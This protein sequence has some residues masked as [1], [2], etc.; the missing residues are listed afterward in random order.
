MGMRKALLASAA[1]G[2]LLWGDPASAG[3][4]SGLV[5]TTTTVLKTT[6]S[7]LGLVID[8]PAP[9]DGSNVN[10]YYG[11]INPFY[12]SINP[13]YGSINPFY[14]SISP[15]WGDISPFWGDINPFYGSISPF[16]GSINPFWGTANPFD[17]SIGPFWQQAGP[18]WGA[19]NTTWTN[20]QASNASDY[21]SLQAQLKAFFAQNASFWNAAVLKYTGKNFNE[22]FAN[23]MLAEYGINPDDPSSLAKIDPVVRSAF[24]LN[25]YDGLM[26]FT[27]VDHVDWW[28]SAVNWSPAL[29]DIQDATSKPII[30]G[31]LDSTFSA[32]DTG[33]QN[34]DFVGGY[35]YY[36]NQH[37]GAVASLIAAAHDGKAIMGI[38]PNVQVNLYN[39]FDQTGTASWTDVQKGIAALYASGAHV[40]NASLGVPGTVLSQEWVNILT[41][42]LL[43]GRSQDLVIVKAAGNDG[44]VQTTNISWLSSLQVPQ[45]LLIVGSVGPTGQISSFSNTPGNACFTVL[46]LCT[47]KLMNHYLVAPGELILVS[48]GHG[49]VTRMTGTSFAAPLV[50]GAVALLDSRWPWLQQHAPE[51]VQIILQ[52]AKDLGAP[53]VDPVY[54]WGELDIQASQSPLNFDNLVVFQPFTYNGN[55]LNPLQTLLPNWS[56]RSLKQSVLTPGQLDIWQN[57]KAYLVAIEP[58]GS[59][60][61]DFTI[62]L[63]TMLVGKNQKTAYG[64]NPFQ[65]YLYQR[66]IDWAHGSRFSN[67]SS[68]NVTL[69]HTAWDLS[70]TT[71]A[72]LPEEQRETG[73]ARAHY[74]MQLT[75]VS[76]GIDFRLGE[77]SGAHGL[78]SELTSGSVQTGVFALATDFD[79][80]TGGV[81]PVLG[82]A[83]GGA[84][85][86]GGMT[87]G[88]VHFSAGFSEKS[89]DHVYID[90][91][92][93]PIHTIP[94][95]SNRAAASVFGMDYALAKNFALNVS[96]TSLDEYDGFLG[97]Q[98]GGV[99][100]FGNGARTGA[101]T[102]GGTAT[103]DGGWTFAASA[104][105]GNTRAGNTGSALSFTSSNMRS[106]AY[107]F[108][109][110]KIGVFGKSDELRVSM[111][112]PLHIENGA[113]RFTSVEVIDRDTGALG[114]VT[115]TWNIAGPREH[116][117]EAIYAVPVLNDRVKLAGFGLVDMN[118]P[119][120]NG[121][122]TGLTAGLQVQVGY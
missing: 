66:L 80:T 48:D 8:A 42:S 65:S 115:Q 108:V 43:S 20:L 17:P 112:Q 35:D 2:C 73:V 53:G 27:G 25:W 113:L 55:S 32:T 46:G 82:L 105:L 98:G 101:A 85:V 77:G 26:N 106:T 121:R 90:Q 116:R 23:A 94:L 62:P 63:S 57:Q 117:I 36:V 40:V 83:S 70:L 21:S 68:Q 97:A 122:K 95:P 12:G 33:V 119:E 6:T 44:S 19:I 47:D 31:I 109:G 38:A 5:G 87:F 76:D 39:P 61:R 58:I 69:G 3:L 22:G 84:Y 37:G 28:M 49:G 34:L 79:P 10:P 78:M 30:V 118:A 7:T 67:F 50:T 114:P 64:D 100:S 71:T 24:F 29:S 45:N 96:Y 16:Y 54:G 74:E 86:Q 110:K 88:A 51:T 120:T 18:E 92:F 107:E 11:S 72:P 89:D 9:A 103:F 1:L 111:T 13:F 56:A 81:N 99:L 52:S 104:T 59:T 14:G 91:T 15:F 4:L 93:G 60:Y 75:N 41:G 102:V